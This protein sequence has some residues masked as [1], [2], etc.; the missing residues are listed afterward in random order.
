MCSFPLDWCYSHGW[1]LLRWHCLRSLWFCPPSYSNGNQLFDVNVFL[2]LYAPYVF[3]CLSPPYLC[4]V[5]LSPVQRSWRPGWVTAGGRAACPTS[6]STSAWASYVD[7]PPNSACLTA[8]S[9]TAVRRSTPCVP[10]NTRSTA[11]C[12]VSPTNTRSWSGRRLFRKSFAEAIICRTH[13]GQQRLF[14]CWSR[15]SLHFFK[16]CWN[17]HTV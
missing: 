7:P 2:Y 11:W 14:A 6:A 5:T 8:S 15:Q 3:M 1:V 13:R 4:V 12:S 17:G 16:G 10:T 9:T